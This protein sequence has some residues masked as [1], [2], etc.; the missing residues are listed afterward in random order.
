MGIEDE[1]EYVE[2]MINTADEMIDLVTI[3][4][5]RQRT[6]KDKTLRLL[7]K[8]IKQGQLREELKQSAYKEC[9]TK[10]SRK[11]GVILRDTRLLIPARL[12]PDILAAAREGHP[13][14]KNN[15]T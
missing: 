5:L 13:A 14:K 3:P 7:L 8:N 11:D 10:F 15:I 12:Q 6:H 2:I 4:I 1:E 9:F